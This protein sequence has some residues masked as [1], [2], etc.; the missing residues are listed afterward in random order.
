MLGVAVLLSEYLEVLS[1]DASIY[2]ALVAL[3]GSPVAVVSAVTAQEMG[4]DGVLAGQLV[5]WTSVLSIFTLFFFVLVL[6]LIGVL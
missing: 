4:S 5:V 2:P 1:F 6:R 3:F